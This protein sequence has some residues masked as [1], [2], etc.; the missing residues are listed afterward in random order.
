M[1]INSFIPTA[2]GAVYFSATTPDFYT[3]RE[4]NEFLREQQQ[5]LAAW[6]KEYGVSG[7]IGGE[8]R[9]IEGIHKA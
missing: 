8:C 9:K 6:F 3:R 7:T 4:C 5:E 2:P 1:V